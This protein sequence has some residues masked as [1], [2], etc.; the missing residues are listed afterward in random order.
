MIRIYS[1]LEKR[2][3]AQKIFYSVIDNSEISAAVYVYCLLLT[4]SSGAISQH[5]LINRIL[6]MNPSKAV[7]DYIIALYNT[8]QMYQELA[9]TYILFIE[10]IT[11]K[12]IFEKMQKAFEKNI[13]DS[14]DNISDGNYPFRIT[15]LGDEILMTKMDS[16]M[17]FYEFKK[18]IIKKWKVK[19]HEYDIRNNIK[20][21]S[22]HAM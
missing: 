5:D 10:K 16:Y 13:K 19:K 20:E 6:D 9:R 3:R 7:F 11:K 12:S 17:G 1:I 14:K 18:K 15:T 22:R 4:D 2:Y 8:S 21:I